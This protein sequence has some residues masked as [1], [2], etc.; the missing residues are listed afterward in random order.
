MRRVFHY[1]PESKAWTDDL[2]A[3]PLSR[4]KEVQDSAVSRESDGYCFLVCSRSSL[5]DFT[6]PGSTIS[7]AAYHE[8]LKRLKEAIR[9][10]IPGFLTKGL[11]VLLLHDNARSHSAAATVNFFELLRLGNSSTSIMQSWF[12]TVGLPSIPKDEKAP[13]RSVLPHQWRCSKWSQEMVT[14]PGRILFDF[15]L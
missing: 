10:K 7:A 12:G 13:Q 4:Q 15:S 11:G 14:C 8:T 5:V 9:R 6:P 2:E 1:I 3:S